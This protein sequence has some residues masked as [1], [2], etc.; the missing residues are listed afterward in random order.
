MDIFFQLF[1]SPEGIMS[2]IVFLAML[3]IGGFFLKLFISK[4]NSKDQ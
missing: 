3:A 2:L 1:S 4:M